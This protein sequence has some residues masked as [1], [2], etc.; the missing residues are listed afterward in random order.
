[1]SAQSGKNLG[2]IDVSTES[3]PL[4]SS[5]HSHRHRNLLVSPFLRLPTE[6]ILKIFVH[7]TEFHEVDQP[8]SL[9][10]ISEMFEIYNSPSSDEHCS[11]LFALTAI[12]HNLREI[13][14]ASPGASL[15]SPLPPLPN[16]SLN[17][18]NMIH[19]FSCNPTLL[20]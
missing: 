18:A 16:Y 13:G 1:M 10:T 11:T 15:T 8:L 9:Y 20:G 12:C 6:L 17:D 3:I 5:I 2:T 4:H 7:A 14:I 19:V